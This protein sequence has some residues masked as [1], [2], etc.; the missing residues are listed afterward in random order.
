M[1]EKNYNNLTLGELNHEFHIACIQGDLNLVKYLLT[2]SELKQH[3]DIHFEKDECVVLA[4][5]YGQL[6]VLQYLLTSSDLKTHPDV[7]AQKGAGF[8]WACT[9]GR[10]DII[11]YFFFDPS[12][13]DNFNLEKHSYE[14]IIRAIHADANKIVEYILNEPEITKHNFNYNKGFILEAACE[15]GRLDILKYLVDLPHFNKDLD[16][17]FKNDT[18]F[19]GASYYGNL[20][21]VE[22]LIFD[23]KL[24]KTKEIENFISINNRNINK[25]QIDRMFNAR[26]LEI[27]LK[28]N[29]DIKPI[30]TKKIKV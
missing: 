15:C 6:G 22:F 30:T 2:S 10:L 7:H 9:N 14:A 1:A 26:D 8:Q 4:C 12:I 11:K 29:Q 19:K 20:D 27:D 21:I 13:S 28:N 18:C 16:F 17:H 25:D 5:K 23:M 3:A 24:E